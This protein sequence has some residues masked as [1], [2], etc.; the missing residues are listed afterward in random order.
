MPTHVR[1][2]A[3]NGGSTVAVQHQ[4]QQIQTL[5][6]CAFDEAFCVMHQWPLNA[7]SCLYTPTYTAVTQT[8]QHHAH[9]HLHG[10][11]PWL[12]STAHALLLPALLV[13][14]CCVASAGSA[15]LSRSPACAEQCCW[16]CCCCSWARYAATC[17][18]SFLQQVFCTAGWTTASVSCAAAVQCNCSCWPASIR[19]SCC[20]NAICSTCHH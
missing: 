10:Y 19:V 20:D 16:C 7:K 1:F 6:V 9:Q 4:P 17:S 18:S 11:T 12:A 14:H 13:A 5:S 15:R 3:A 8:T 2:E